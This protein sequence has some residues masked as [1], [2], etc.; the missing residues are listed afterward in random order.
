MILCTKTK[1]MRHNKDIIWLLDPNQSTI[2]NKLFSCGVKNYVCDR[3]IVCPL[4]RGIVGCVNTVNQRNCF[5]SPGMLLCG[6]GIVYFVYLVRLNNIYNGD[7]VEKNINIIALR[8]HIVLVKTNNKNSLTVTK[9][10]LL[11]LAFSVLYSTIN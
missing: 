3:Q 5:I 1:W 11:L 7:V 4:L 9:Y 8:Q 6:P 2:P 10:M